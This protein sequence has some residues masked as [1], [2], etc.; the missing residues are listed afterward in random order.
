MHPTSR[1]GQPQQS[2][3]TP[4]QDL[5]QLLTPLQSAYS[6]GELGLYSSVKGPADGGLPRIRITR[7]RI[8]ESRQEPDL[9]EVEFYRYQDMVLTL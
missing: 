2:T 6:H 4:L 1:A 5:A 7:A 9:A 3:S 8:P